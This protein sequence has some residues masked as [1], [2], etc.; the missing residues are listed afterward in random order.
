[1]PHVLAMPYVL[2]VLATP[3]LMVFMAQKVIE[4]LRY[5]DTY[6]Q[7]KSSLIVWCQC[8]CT[9]G[10]YAEIKMQT[11]HVVNQ[12]GWLESIPVEY[13]LYCLDDTDD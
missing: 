11:L 12:G 4:L 9:S 2:D 5:S 13:S 10:T 8:D 3:P 6:S 7:I 1:M